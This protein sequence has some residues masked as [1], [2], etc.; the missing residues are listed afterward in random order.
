M[1]RRAWVV[2]RRRSM[3]LKASLQRRL[4]CTLGFHVRRVL[5][6]QLGEPT[7]RVAAAAQPGPPANARLAAVRQPGLGGWGQGRLYP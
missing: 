5:H 7:A 1:Q 4:V 2:T 3:V 6:R